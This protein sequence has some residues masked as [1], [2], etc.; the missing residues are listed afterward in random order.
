MIDQ[1]KTLSEKFLKKGFWLY[2]FSFIIA[3]IWYIIKIII[4]WELTVSEVGI[5]YGIISLITMLSAYNDL[6]MTESLKYFIPKFVTEKKYDKV[7]SILFYAFFSQI[8]T[9]L[10]IASFFFFWADYIATNYFKTQEA[11]ETL[12]VFAFFFIWLNIFQTINQFF[13]AVQDTFYNKLTETIRMLF[14]MFSV[15]FI[16][17]WDLSSLINYSFTWLIWLY[18]WLIISLFVLYNK[19]YKIYFK[20]EK[21]IIEKQ[22]IKKI[23]KYAW[24]VFIW[25][26]AWAILGQMDM[27]MIIYLLWTTEA[28][29]YTNYLSIIWIPFMIIWPIFALLFPIFAEMYSTWEYKKIKL[30]KEIITKNLLIIWIAFNILLFIFAEII[31]YI[32][33]WEKFIESWIILKYSIWF[34]IFNFLLQINFNIMA[35][36]WKIKDRVKIIFIAVIFNFIMNVILIKSMWVYWASLATWIWWVIIFILWEY[37]LWKKYRINFDSILILKNIFF[38]WILW[39]F[40]YYLILPIFEWLNRINSLW[41]LSLIWILWF[42]I[43][44][45]IN[46]KEFKFFI[47]EVKKLRK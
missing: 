12:K 3:P 11:T 38:I 10:I 9:S 5:L 22:L 43:I 20:N 4:S 6:W 47:L 28:W 18:I 16:F 30:V 2:L 26:S 31:A 24:L 7:K 37:F 46:I 27:Q 14:I 29:Y 25:A 21:I 15:I 35:G 34:L 17:F 44:I 23:S 40:I 36:I 1:Y 45:I 32:L 41:L 13:L 33:F 39:F 8:I 19:Y 42:M